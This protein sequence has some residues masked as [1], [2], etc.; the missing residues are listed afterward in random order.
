M[1]PPPNKIPGH[2]TDPYRN[3]KIQ[4]SSRNS[5]NAA[6]SY[7]V[8]NK[9]WLF[10]NCLYLTYVHETDHQKYIWSLRTARNTVLLGKLTG[11]QPVKKFPT[12]YGS[13]ISLR[14]SPLPILSQYQQIQIPTY[15]FLIILNT[16]LPSTSVSPNW[17][18]SLSFPP[19]NSCK[20]LSYPHT[21]YIPRPSRYSEFYHPNN[22]GFCQPRL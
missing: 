12:L 3:P 4:Y 21:C 13:E 2:A 17:S 1:N 10:S 16:I 15:H 20:R 8:I 14:H 18:L 22:I 7:S 6:C 11:F 19:P 5:V 9:F